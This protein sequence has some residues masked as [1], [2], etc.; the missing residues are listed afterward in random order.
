[1]N[2]V[3]SRDGEELESQSSEGNLTSMGN[4][5]EIQIHKSSLPNLCSSQHSQGIQLIQNRMALSL[6]LTKSII[7][8]ILMAHIHVF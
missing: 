8:P 2:V 6:F 4:N 5:Y 1:M 3:F 7:Q